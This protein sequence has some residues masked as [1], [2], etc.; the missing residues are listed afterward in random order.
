MADSPS[1]ISADDAWTHCGLPVAKVNL[2]T[3]PDESLCAQCEAVAIH[4]LT[5]EQEKVADLLERATKA[6]EAERELT[7]Q[8]AEDMKRTHEASEAE[9]RKRSPTYGMPPEEREAWLAER[10]AQWATERR[11]ESE[12]EPR[13]EDLD[14]DLEGLA[15]FKD[16]L[17]D[18][19]SIDEW[20][21]RERRR[22]QT[23]GK[24]LSRAF[25]AG[26][27]AFKRRD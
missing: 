19:A 6:V 10:N 17:V 2:A 3:G 20:D 21:R 11:Q 24:R 5:E 7:R 8:D 1:H 22:Q 26:W 9:A 16:R 27:C 12:W 15:L 13:M 18:P 23:V 14:S 25:M 4:K